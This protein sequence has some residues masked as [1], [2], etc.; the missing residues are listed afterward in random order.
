MELDPINHPR[1]LECPIG[2]VPVQ[3]Y[4]TVLECRTLQYRTVQYSTSSKVLR[5]SYSG[6]ISATRTGVLPT[7]IDTDKLRLRLHSSRNER[8]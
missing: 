8:H 2:A 7:G 5:V 1:L 3:Y 4:S 6:D